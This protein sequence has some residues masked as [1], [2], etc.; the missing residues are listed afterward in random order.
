MAQP[1]NRKPVF[2]LSSLEG[3]RGREASQRLPDAVGSILYKYHPKR[4]HGDLIW[5]NVDAFVC[6]LHIRCVIWLRKG[7]KFDVVSTQKSFNNLL[8]LIT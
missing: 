3:F 8:G 7:H 4:G 2:L 1:L 6:F 5:V